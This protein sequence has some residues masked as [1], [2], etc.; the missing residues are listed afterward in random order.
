MHSS[1][2]RCQAE[3]RAGQPDQALDAMLGGTSLSLFLL[4]YVQKPWSGFRVRS[5]W[6][7]DRDCSPVDPEIL[8][9]M[10]GA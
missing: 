2:V 3:R 10:A 7:Y 5:G 4:V 8:L 6:T 1:I 9:L